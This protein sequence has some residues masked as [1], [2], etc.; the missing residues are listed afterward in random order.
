MIGFSKKILLLSGF[1]SIQETD[2]PITDTQF[3]KVM[4]KVDDLLGTNYRG[5]HTIRKIAAY[6][7]YMQSS[8]NIGLVMQLLNPSSEAMTLT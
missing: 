4:A 5:T 7:V 8:Y 3:Y 1:P 6:H 2:C